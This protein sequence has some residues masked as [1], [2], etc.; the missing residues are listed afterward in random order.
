MNQLRPQEEIKD[1]ISDR[2]ERVVAAYDAQGDEPNIPALAAEFNLSGQ[3]IRN[4]LQA[5]GIK[6]VS[7]AKR[8]RKPL[9]GLRAIGPVH[10]HVAQ[11]VRAIY[12]EF[13]L[14]TGSPPSVT[15]VA[16]H[17]GLNRSSF[18]EIIAGRRDIR[19]SELVAI[20]KTAN[21]SVS[22]LVT[23]KWKSNDPKPSN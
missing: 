2:D 12:A 9:S 8:G 22:D 4:I 6:P 19:L 20:A 14:A 11:V 21:M 10:S 1:T 7:K 16:E 3:T 17:I 18:M 5:H 23:P 15:L 13:E